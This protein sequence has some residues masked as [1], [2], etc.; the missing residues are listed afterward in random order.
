MPLNPSR[1]YYKSVKHCVL[2]LFNGLHAL[3]SWWNRFKYYIYIPDTVTQ[4]HNIFIHHFLKAPYACL[5]FL[6]KNDKSNTSPGWSQLPYF[7]EVSS[8]S[9]H[10]QVSLRL[11]LMAS[12]IRLLPL[13]CSVFLWTGSHWS[14]TSCQQV[15]GWLGKTCWSCT[16]VQERETSRILSC[17]K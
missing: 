3:N 8:M 2:C 1:M 12:T 9:I 6:L 10:S 4:M 16:C 7:L 14:S 17:C 5:I 11:C 15:C 13:P